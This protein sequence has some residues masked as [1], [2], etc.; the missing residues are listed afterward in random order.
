MKSSVFAIKPES[1]RKTMHLWKIT[2]HKI[3]KDGFENKICFISAQEPESALNKVQHAP[4]GWHW[5]KC[6]DT[7]CKDRVYAIVH[8]IENDQIFYFILE[9]NG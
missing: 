5:K 7:D 6:A 1:R 4:K 2:V 9:D 8:S 3:H